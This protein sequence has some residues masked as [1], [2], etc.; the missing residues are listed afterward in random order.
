MDA[1]PPSSNFPN[2][3]DNQQLKS[4]LI[5]LLFVLLL[6][7]AGMSLYWLMFRRGYI[8]TQFFKLDTSIPEKARVIDYDQVFYREPP[9]PKITDFN[10]GKSDHSLTKILKGFFYNYD[11]DNQVLEILNQFR[12]YAYLQQL[13]VDLSQIVGFYCWLEEVDGSAGLVKTSSL[14]Y[15]V[16]PDGRDIIMPGERFVT[17]DLL[18]DFFTSQSFL[19]I[20]L[21]DMFSLENTNYVQKLIMIG[22]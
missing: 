7:L 5:L 20:Q 12:G 3:N 14:E 4:W 17:L 1:A 8:S 21:R 2:S 16:N 9:E 13:E 22:C 19:I 11:E 10:S 6:I 15:Q 18:P